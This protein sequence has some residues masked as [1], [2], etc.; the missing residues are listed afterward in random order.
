MRASR[1]VQL[2]VGSTYQGTW[3]TVYLVVSV[4][5][6]TSICDMRQSA[7]LLAAIDKAGRVNAAKAEDKV[8]AKGVF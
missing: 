6:G 1:S 8:R 2:E 3:L 7:E 5:A 4:H